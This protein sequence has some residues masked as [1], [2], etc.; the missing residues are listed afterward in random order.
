MSYINLVTSLETFLQDFLVHSVLSNNEYK[1]NLLA[2]DKKIGNKKIEVSEVLKFDLDSY[3]K[4]I[5]SNYIYHKINHVINLYE[6][7]FD[8]KFSDKPK[9]IEKIFLLGMILYIGMEK[10]KRGK[11]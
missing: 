1:N 4:R 7:T 2:K 5:L 9:S 11:T 10:Q 3:L 8:I 6:A